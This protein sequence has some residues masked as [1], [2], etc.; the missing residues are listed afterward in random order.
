MNTVITFRGNGL[1][2]LRM[3]VYAFALVCALLVTWTPAVAATNG[4]IQMPHAAPRPAV[5]LDAESQS[6]LIESHAMWH[7]ETFAELTERWWQWLESIPY[8][9]GPSADPSGANCGINQEGSVWFL[10]APVGGTFNRACTVPAGK[11]I[12]SP[13]FVVIDDY[14]CPD[15]TFGPAPGQSLEGFLQ[16][17]ITQFVD[18]PHASTTAT[19]DST[20]LHVRHV[21]TSLFAFT[22]AASNVQGDSC[23]TGSPQLGVSDGYFVFIDPLPPGQHIL[24][25]RSVVFGSLTDVTITLTVK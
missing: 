24:H 11:A 12:L 17:D 15:P 23:I 8:G 25:L 9:V 21:K 22:A 2:S 18:D 4:S 6:I 3:C 14:P 16:A 19:L 13:L 5:V 1:T 20:P 10:A 7:G